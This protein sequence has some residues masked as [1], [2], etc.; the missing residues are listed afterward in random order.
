MGINYLAIMKYICATLPAKQNL[1]LLVVRDERTNI[2]PVD[3]VIIKIGTIEKA[4]GRFLKENENKRILHK[5]I[6]GDRFH[7]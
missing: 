3:I 2:Y 1:L 5:N 6:S 4:N 7:V